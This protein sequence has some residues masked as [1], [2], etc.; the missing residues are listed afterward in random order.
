L[1]PAAKEPAPEGG[2]SPSKH[3]YNS[4]FS[5]IS[6][7]AFQNEPHRHFALKGITP[8]RTCLYP[9]RLL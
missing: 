1:P 3:L 9:R 6:T 2:T 7:K 8:I 4:R 5:A